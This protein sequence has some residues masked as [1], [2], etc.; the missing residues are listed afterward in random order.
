MVAGA[1][2]VGA[3]VVV[4]ANIQQMTDALIRSNR[5]VLREGRMP[6]LG[7]VHSSIMVHGA[8][9]AEPRLGD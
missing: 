3:A 1:L 8:L 5:M 2:V 7:C 9:A 6:L 4:A